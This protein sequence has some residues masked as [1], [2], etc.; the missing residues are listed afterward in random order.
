MRTGMELYKCDK[1][2]A[3]HRVDFPIAET[4]AEYDGLIKRMLPPFAVF[5]NGEC[6][7]MRACNVNKCTQENG[8]PILGKAIIL[9]TV[10]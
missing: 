5:E 7:K 10:K 6:R 4:Q 9:K 2:K 3:E 1:C 8:E